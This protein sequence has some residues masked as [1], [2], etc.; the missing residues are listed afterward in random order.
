M[1]RGC[2]TWA[3]GLNAAAKLHAGA[4]GADAAAD[5]SS[6]GSEP[7]LYEDDCVTLHSDRVVVKWCVAC[8]IAVLQLFTIRSNEPTAP[9]SP[10]ARLLLHV[11]MLLASPFGTQRSQSRP[12]VD[13]VRG[14]WITR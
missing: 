11:A 7:P 1:E 12:S 10:R 3:A 14:G 5:G 6:A 4:A 9:P 13:L 2:E 8:W